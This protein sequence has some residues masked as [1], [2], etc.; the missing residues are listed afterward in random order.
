MPL[1]PIHPPKHSHK[2]LEK[3]SPIPERETKTIFKKEVITETSREREERLQRE[4]ED[5]RERSLVPITL[6]RHKASMNIIDP[7]HLEMLSSPST[8]PSE[9]RIPTKTSCCTIS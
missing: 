9:P 1:K 5:L 8:S 2:T 4:A 7:E 3:L 6:T